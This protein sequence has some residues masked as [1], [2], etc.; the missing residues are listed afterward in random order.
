MRVELGKS[1]S[2][3]ETLQNPQTWTTKEDN[4]IDVRDGKRAATGG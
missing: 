1:V 3:K 2:L 4:K